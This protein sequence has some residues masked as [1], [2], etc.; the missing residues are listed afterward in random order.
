MRLPQQVID[1]LDRLNG[2]G[3]EACAVGGCVRDSLLGLSPQDYDV[4]TAAPPASV[5]A[6]FSDSRV[7]ATGLRHGTLTVL[8]Q[9]MAVEITTYRTESAYTDHRHPDAVH[10]TDELRED[11]ARRDFTVNAMAFHPRT[12]LA[13]PFGGQA[14]LALRVIRC[15]GEPRRRFEEDAL[16]VLRALRFA[17]ALD[18]TIEPQTA[19]AAREK[20]SLLAYVSAERICSELVKLLCGQG[21][22]RVLTGYPEILTQILPGLCAGKELSVTA[23]A[24]ENAPCEPEL[25]LAALLCGSFEAADADRQLRALRID[26][27]TR[28][29]VTRLI[30]GYDM[31]FRTDTAA[32]RRAL[33]NF[34][35]ELFF[36]VLQLKQAFAQA[37]NRQDETA[38][39]ACAEQTAREILARGECVSLR[40]LAV[41]GEDLIAAGV[42]PGRQ[43]GETLR[44][45]LDAV[46]DGRAVNE[47]KALLRFWEEKFS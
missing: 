14:D 43:V 11:L 31:T 36:S 1:I 40:Q 9:G 20:R 21:V 5:A 32:V 19:L 41:N 30:E 17:S 42:A 26:N 15:V 8:S 4:A 28:H 10:F 12:G 16:R 7:I 34:T 45:L 2:A 29:R 35:P 38:A 18:F 6:L 24:V 47:K 44:T 37:E 23:A 39:L 3:F 27:A 22:R 13:D 33:S 25:R 46:L